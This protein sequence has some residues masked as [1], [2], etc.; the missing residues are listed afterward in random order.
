M[1]GACAHLWREAEAEQEAEVVEIGER[2]RV[3]HALE[4]RAHPQRAHLDRERVV[5]E[6][7][8]AAAQERVAEAGHRVLPADSTAEWLDGGH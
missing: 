6:V 8:R 3:L 2:E 7:R 1:R 4:A 5:R